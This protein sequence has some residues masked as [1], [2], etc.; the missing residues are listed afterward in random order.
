MLLA[1]SL[2]VPNLLSGGER[3]RSGI[4]IALRSA[5]LVGPVFRRSG[6]VGMLGRILRGSGR[7]GRWLLAVGRSGMSGRSGPVGRL[8][9]DSGRYLIVGR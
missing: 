7:V 9:L 6:P 4:P 2:E 5:R 8:Y 1:W 3:R